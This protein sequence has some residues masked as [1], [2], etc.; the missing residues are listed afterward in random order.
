MIQLGKFEKYLIEEFFDD[1]RAG[2]MTPSH[3]HPPG[4][5][6]HRQHGRGIGRDAAGG[7]HP[8]GSAARHR[9][10]AHAHAASS[11]AGTGTASAGAVPGAKSP[12]SV[13]EGAAGLTTA[14]VRSRPA[15]PTSAATLPGRTGE[16]RA[17]RCW[18]ATRTAG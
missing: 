6:H 12:L 18:S 3:V 11:P 10:D 2:A 5:V 14:T 17:R 7:L 9:P 4:R 8:R 13:P 15:A 1:Y 16:R